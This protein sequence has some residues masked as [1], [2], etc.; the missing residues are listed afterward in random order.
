VHG[1]GASHKA[2]AHYAE[3]QAQDLSQCPTHLSSLNRLVLILELPDIVGPVSDSDPASD[4]DLHIAER[5]VCPVW[6]D[7]L[8]LAVRPDLDVRSKLEEVPDRSDCLDLGENSDSEA[9]L[10][11]NVILDTVDRGEVGLFCSRLDQYHLTLTTA[12]PPMPPMVLIF[13][14]SMAMV[15]ATK[16]QPTTIIRKPQIWTTRICISRLL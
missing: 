8:D 2:P 5:V 16:I 4:P 1:K 9:T 6:D 15:Q 13:Q 12:E 14:P 7:C 11:L 10:V 3:Q